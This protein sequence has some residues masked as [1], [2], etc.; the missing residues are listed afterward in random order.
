MRKAVRLAAPAVVAAAALILSGCG[1]DNGDNGDGVEGQETRQ[2]ADDTTEET[3]G[4]D[5]A[6]DGP[7]EGLDGLWLSQGDDD[8][9]VLIIT[10]GSATFFLPDGADMCSGE[11]A[12][13]GETARLTL[14]CAMGS[15]EW[16][17][18]V[19]TADGDSM[20]VAWD[21]G[22]TQD[23]ARIPDL[24]GLED[25]DFGDIGDLGGIGGSAETDS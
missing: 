22:A 25:L 9:N 12:D 11:V 7:A 8:E 1:S 5:D 23:Y 2:P 4:G 18:A 24:E 14:E 10:G 16:T 13:E 15:T 17:Y 6:T 20:E 21:N 3:D 19:A